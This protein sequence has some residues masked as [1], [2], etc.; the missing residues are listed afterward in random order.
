M[1]V[2]TV[3][4]GGGPWGRGLDTPHT[5]HT[6]RPVASND[7]PASVAITSLL[8]YVS[9][10]FGADQLLGRPVVFSWVGARLGQ[11]RGWWQAQGTVGRGVGSLVGGLLHL[12]PA[13]KS[14]ATPSTSIRAAWPY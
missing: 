14:A 13:P 12:L 1:S 10:W 2:G 5:H 7:P 6:G 3:Q 11:A 8:S 9:L 4:W